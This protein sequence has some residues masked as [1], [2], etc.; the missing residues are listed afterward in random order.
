MKKFLASFLVLMMFVALLPTAA[1]ADGIRLFNGKIEQRLGVSYGNGSCIHTL[2]FC[3][4][5]IYHTVYQKE[6]VLIG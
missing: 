1:F 6:L 2:L 5:V 4:D 3:F